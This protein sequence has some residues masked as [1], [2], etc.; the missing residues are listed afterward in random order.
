MVSYKSCMQLS[1][2]RINTICTVLMSVIKDDYTHGEFVS[3][4]EDGLR[5]IYFS[6]QLTP[7]SIFG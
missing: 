5:K 3:H 7:F 6:N 1:S 4:I 2:F